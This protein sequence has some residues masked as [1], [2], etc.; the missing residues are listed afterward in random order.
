[1]AVT[2]VQKGGPARLQ[3]LGGVGKSTLAVEYA[4]LFEAAWPGG[5]FWLN[6]SDGQ[7]Q[8]Q[9][10]AE[11]A[12]CLGLGGSTDAER[13]SA[14]RRK[15]CTMEAPYLWI[16]DGVPA[17]I[18]L[19]RLQRLCTPGGAGCT[20]ITTR[21]RA[22]KSLGAVLDLEVLPPEDA[23]DLLLK[24]RGGQPVENRVDALQLCAKVGYLPLAL[25][26][27]AAL[28]EQS[29]LPESAWI[30]R[31]DDPGDDALEWAADLEEELPSGCSKS[32][33]AVMWQSLQML[34]KEESW[35]L[36]LFLSVRDRSYIYYTLAT[37]LFVLVYLSTFGYGFQYLCKALIRHV[38]DIF[39]VR[40]GDHTGG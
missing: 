8:E 12:S 14:L 33:A 31:L 3:G 27:L 26:L 24:R 38:F 1:M 20:L 2:G 30:S 13:A 39:L 10:E 32:I 19:E 34:K 40:Q 5:I 23:F 22:W 7:G 37:A 15:L 29:P 35:T 21:S 4:T 16:L 17:D 25:D 18:S 11:L 36:L 9:R 6:L 28:Q